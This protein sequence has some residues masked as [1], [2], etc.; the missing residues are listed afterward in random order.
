MSTATRIPLTQAVTIAEE[1][2]TTLRPF[3]ARLEVAGSI[4]RRRDS[5]GDLELVAIPKMV[6]TGKPR[7]NFVYLSADVSRPYK[8]IVN[9]QIC[10]RGLFLD[11][12]LILPL[13]GVVAGEAGLE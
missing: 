3:C 7:H 13:W 4:R 9:P 1:V 5:I 2:C 10:I 11:G 12:S 8:V 6:P